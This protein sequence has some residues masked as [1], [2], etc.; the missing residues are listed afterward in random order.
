VERVY[1]G[2]GATGGL[3][4]FA[5][6]HQAGADAIVA[7]EVC[8]WKE[9]RW[10]QDAGLGL[11]L[12]DHSTTEERAVKNLAAYL[13][14]TLGLRTLFIPTASPCLHYTA[15]GPVEARWPR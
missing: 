8:Q 5:E 14:D 9:L 3:G 15:G 2:I 11:I 12:L 13:A 10:A 4:R 7:N 1:L 6:A